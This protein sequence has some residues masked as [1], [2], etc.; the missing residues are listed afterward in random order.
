[1]RVPGRIG[2]LLG[3]R[4]TSLTRSLRVSNGRLKAATPWRPRHPSARE[5]YRA[6]A[7]A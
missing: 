7:A 3:D 6:M 4:L 5:G 1:L 2:L